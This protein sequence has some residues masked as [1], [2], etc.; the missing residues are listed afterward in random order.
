MKRSLLIPATL[1][2]LATASCQE[3]NKP[4]LLTI[5]SPF[6]YSS[7]PVGDPSMDPYSP[8]DPVQAQ[9]W[10]KPPPQPEQLTPSRR[11]PPPSAA[12]AR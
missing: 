1:I 9:Q 10:I 3:Q 12:P 8:N 7:K 2:A 4:V 5:G 6:E 11:T